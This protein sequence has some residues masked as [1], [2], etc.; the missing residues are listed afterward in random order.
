MTGTIT[1][2]S[3]A[4]LTV[5]QVAEQLNR[6][7]ETIQ[8]W[9]D[10]HVLLPFIRINGEPRFA[11]ADVNALERAIQRQGERPFKIQMVHINGNGLDNRWANLF[12]LPIGVIFPSIEDTALKEPPPTA[13]EIEDLNKL[14][15][16]ELRRLLDY[17]RE[18]GVL[19]WKVDHEGNKAGTVVVTEII[20]ED[21]N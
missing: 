2:I 6:Y 14:D 11:Q 18:T 15:R 7:P 10:K 19:R 21:I 16:A 1:A 20:G 3:K 4:M 8:N 13:A 5:D 17:D 12:S 9:V